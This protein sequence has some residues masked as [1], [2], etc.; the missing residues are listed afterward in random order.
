M[1][2]AT[3]PEVTATDPTT[4]Q[5]D[6]VLLWDSEFPGDRNRD[7]KRLRSDLY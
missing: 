1:S 2:F 6:P 3:A 7:G 5:P 4:G